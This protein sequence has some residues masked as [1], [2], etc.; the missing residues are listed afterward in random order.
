MTGLYVFLFGIFFV[1]LLICFIFYCKHRA[2]PFFEDLRSLKDTFIS[3]NDALRF[4]EKHKKLYTFISRVFIPIEEVKL[5]KYEYENL[6]NNRKS[7]NQDFVKREL[8]KYNILFSNIE[9]KSLD[10]QQRKACIVNEDA[11]LVVAGA[12]SGKTLTICGKVKYLLDKGV[13][14][15]EILCIS[16]TNKVCDELK[17]RLKKLTNCDIDVLTFHKLALK[18]LKNNKIE[19]N[20]ADEN[21]ENQMLEK[22][23]RGIRNKDIKTLALN[24]MIYCDNYVN[25]QIESKDTESLMVT[26]KDTIKHAKEL[27]K[28]QKYKRGLVDLITLAEEKVKSQHEL[29]IANFLFINGINYEYES[30]YKFLNDK[31]KVHYRPDF[32]LPDYD[33]YI[34]HFGIDETGHASWLKDEEKI[35]EYEKTMEWKKKLHEENHTK[36]ICTYSFQRDELINILLE[37][38]KTFNVE[39]KPCSTELIDL[40][41]NI[42]DFDSSFLATVSS[43]IKLFKNRGFE[44]SQF[45]KFLVDATP[46]ERRVLNLIKLIYINYQEQLEKDGLI[47]FEDM[48]NSANKQ[49]VKN[50]ILPNYK[51]IIVD[52]YQDVSINKINLLKNLIKKNSARL[53]AVGDDWQSIYRFAGSEVSLISKFS[54]E[55]KHN[56]MLKVEKTYRNSE[57]LIEVSGKFIQRNDNQIKKDLKSDKRCYPPIII[58]SFSEKPLLISLDKNSLRNKEFI[59]LSKDDPRIKLLVNTIKDIKEK[60]CKDVLLLVRNNFDLS[61]IQLWIENKDLGIDIIKNDNQSLIFKKDDIVF[62]CLTIH[63]S[64]GLEADAVILFDIKEGYRG[65]PDTLGDDNILKFVIASREEIEY[66]EDRRLFYVALTRTRTSVYIIAR[67]REQSRFLQELNSDFR[68]Y[69]ESDMEAFKCPKCGGNLVHIPEK[70]FY[71]CDNYFGLECTY[72][73]PASNDSE[74]LEIYDYMKDLKIMSHHGLYIPCKILDIEWV[75]KPIGEAAIKVQ[76]AFIVGNT[77]VT[78]F[79]TYINKNNVDRDILKMSRFIMTLRKGDLLDPFKHFDAYKKKYIG[80]QHKV[81]VVLRKGVIEPIFNSEWFFE[82]L[83][84]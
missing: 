48:I 75:K 17:E 41:N 64:K 4:L 8:S 76:Y 59:G 50:L 84:K 56:E 27:S 70:G 31:K 65:L 83:Y 54:D 63:K 45:N 14:P 67:V 34:E 7:L 55:F 35:V 60:D 9:G 1:I 61:I 19:Y 33:I 23:L 40:L 71:G 46:Q 77:K 29:E 57:N 22:A 78:E 58:K 11:N 26:M 81:H 82:P 15:S 38:L 18:I 74:L 10:E 39:M 13:K 62:T 25:L 72:T 32:Y 51:Y 73:T 53:V 24:L 16:F 36:L 5:L 47:D 49:F 20:I 80:A 68:H 52:E 28:L 43:F 3:Y 44:E 79:F 21:R 37:E 6:F 2:I 12:G 42:Y 69:L 66:A 30:D